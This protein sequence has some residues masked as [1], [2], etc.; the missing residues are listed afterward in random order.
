MYGLQKWGSSGMERWRDYHNAFMAA[1]YWYS[2]NI[3]V[4]VCSKALTPCIE[5]VLLIQP[6]PFNIQYSFVDNFSLGCAF[7]LKL[8]WNIDRTLSIHNVTNSDD[9]IIV[10]VFG[11]MIGL[12]SYVDLNN[13]LW[14]VAVHCPKGNVSIP[15]ELS[16]AY[17]GSIQN[18]RLRL[19]SNDLTLKPYSGQ[20]RFDLF[21]KKILPL[22]WA[23]QDL[24]TFPKSASW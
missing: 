13:D 15:N 21:L 18:L 8:S 9:I 2:Q 1:L 16:T 7:V 5:L 11:I 19:D 24:A 17:I 12:L 4:R 22:I 6:E 3:L 14:L 20:N 23:V 10:T